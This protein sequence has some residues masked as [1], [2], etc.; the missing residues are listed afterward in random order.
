MADFL[1][2]VVDDLVSGSVGTINAQ[3]G[4]CIQENLR[5][6]TGAD[7]YVVINQTG[8]LPFPH[9]AKEQYAFQALVDSNDMVSGQTAC[10]AVYDR[11]NERISVTLAGHD[12]LWIRAIALPQSVP[13]GPSAGQPPERF[14]FSVNFDALIRKDGGT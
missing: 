12:V 7:T 14:M 13:L 2:A 5:R 1:K 3:S 4:V 11:L 9:A 10:R 6:E 8:G